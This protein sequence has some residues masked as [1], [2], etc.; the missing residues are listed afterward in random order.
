MRTNRKITTVEELYNH[1]SIKEIVVYDKVKV[2][3]LLRC[4]SN[5]WYHFDDHEESLSLWIEYYCT[6]ACY[7]L[8]IEDIVS[9]CYTIVLPYQLKYHEYIGMKNN[10]DYY[11]VDLSAKTTMLI[12]LGYKIACPDHDLMRMKDIKEMQ[13]VDLIYKL[14]NHYV[15]PSYLL[16]FKKLC[17]SV[18]VKNSNVCF[19][20]YYS[21]GA[22]TLCDLIK[23]LCKALY[24][25]QSY[26]DINYHNYKTLNLN[27]YINRRVVFIYLSD[28]FTK[29]ELVK[30]NKINTFQ[31]KNKVIIRLCQGYD[32][33]HLKALESI[34]YNHDKMK[35]IIGVYNDLSITYFDMVDV[36][37][38]L[39]HDILWWAISDYIE[40]YWLIH[41]FNI[42]L[43]MRHLLIQYL[44]SI[45]GV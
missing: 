10:E 29:K 32:P 33:Y 19:N 21:S 35:K 14:M 41:Q 5:I 30:L 23:Y 26:Y 39:D 25:E 2:K 13:D 1:S 6:Q 20:D 27:H 37:Q 38:K 45:T 34:L 11:L 36:V 24:G 42:I 8:L 22:Y 28:D 12:L 31:N 43:D 9:K 16:A 18:F 7:K 15:D 3:G 44:M 4:S 17:K 40:H